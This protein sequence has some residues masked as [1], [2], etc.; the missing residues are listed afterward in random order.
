MI[1]SLKERFRVALTIAPYAVVVIC[2]S[3]AA[4]EPAAILE[5]GHPYSWDYNG[6]SVV[7]G[8]VFFANA[9]ADHG[10]EPWVS[11]GTPEGTVLLRDLASGPESSDPYGFTSFGR[12]VVFEAWDLDHG[13]ELWVSDGTREGTVLLA[14]IRPGPESS[15]PSLLPATSTRAFF[16][17]DGL[18]ATDGTPAGTTKLLENEA[19]GCCAATTLDDRLFIATDDGEHGWEL[20][21]SDGTEAGTHLLKDVEPGPTSSNPFRLHSASGRIFFS[22]D[23]DFSD[24]HWGDELWV[25]DGT[26]E[27]TKPMLQG[28]HWDG[29]LW[30]VGGRLAFTG[31]DLASFDPQLGSSLWLSDGTP[32]GTTAFDLLQAGGR[33]SELLTSADD[34]VF[35]VAT[36]LEGCIE[37]LWLR[38]L[39]I[40]DGTPGGTHLVA[41]CIVVPRSIKADGPDPWEG[42][43]SF[44]GRL[45][46]TGIDGAHGREP[47]VS[48]G[49]ADGTR[50]LA[51]L[52]PGPEGSS[53]FG[54]LERFIVAGE[55]LFFSGAG[56][57]WVYPLVDRSPRFRRGDA[58]ADGTIDVSDA[59]ATLGLLFIGGPPTLPCQKTSDTNDSGDLDISDAVT[60][61]THLFLG[62]A[63]L[64]E[65]FT[66]CGLDP[67]DDHL[68]CGEFAGCPE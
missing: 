63:A 64:P 45:Y 11:D 30:S 49:A 35:F 33:W 3:A 42:S 17:A 20:W 2:V 56:K 1:M 26:P 38:D 46:F 5:L 52:V 39:W 14:D 29:E 32:E 19:V 40:S 43:T 59:I 66:S 67:S 25:S 18:W 65:P 54:S 13:R 36:G 8:R 24:N 27:G 41:E 21:F 15:F 9:D 61:L 48:D 34:R 53:G 23:S 47:W 50:I 7:G 16:V 22:T 44:D 10:L 31:Y 28:F 55:R 4:V 51:D 68:P 60:L 37:P 62:T 6:N 58:N 57:L 12:L